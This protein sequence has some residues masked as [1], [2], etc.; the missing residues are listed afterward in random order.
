[1]AK[2]FAI[3]PK[4]TD[5]QARWAIDLEKKAIGARPNWPD[6]HRSSGM[7]YTRVGDFEEAIDS[8]D[9]YAQME[10]E[11]HT[12]S[13]KNRIR[14]DVALALSY[15]AIAAFNL[16]EHDRAREDLQLAEGALLHLAFVDASLTD[17]FIPKADDWEYSK[18]DNWDNWEY[19][20]IT[21]ARRGI[22]EARRLMRLQTE[23][24]EEEIVDRAIA[25]GAFYVDRYPQDSLAILNYCQ[26]LVG[27]GELEK[28]SELCRVQ[29]MALNENSGRTRL[30]MI[31]W[32][33]LLAP[34]NDPDLLHKGD[35]GDP[36]GARKGIRRHHRQ[37]SDANGTWHGTI[38][39][40]QLRQSGR[41][42][43]RHQQLG[44]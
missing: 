22:D 39:I 2:A 13:Y 14:F 33:Y 21:N 6:S 24:S 5:E 12:D 16:G 1:M 30:T 4:I 28:H 8:L 41:D 34:S 15:R 35:R 43:H 3:T 36:A 27:A 11:Q 31:P 42:A 23:F 37:V 9:T 26:L 44:L 7:L 32:A 20:L 17:A 25:S 19:W 18:A 29:L 10:W 38:P 40:G